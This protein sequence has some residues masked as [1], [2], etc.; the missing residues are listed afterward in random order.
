MMEMSDILIEG[1]NNWLQKNQGIA[2]S[3]FLDIDYCI[4]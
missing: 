1:F 3:T 2:I 4:I